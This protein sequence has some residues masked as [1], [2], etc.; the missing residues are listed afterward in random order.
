MQ[1]EVISTTEQ[2]LALG[3]E[4]QALE[5]RD[6][7][8]SLYVAHRFVSAWWLAY[9]DDPAY[10]LHT[11]I[12]RHNGELVAVAPLVIASRVIRGQPIR[13]LRW[14]S[15]GDYLGPVMAPQHA[16]RA[17]LTLIGAIQPGDHWDR[18]VLPYMRTDSP[19]AHSVLRSEHN[20]SLTPFVECPYI[21]VDRYADFDDFCARA[22]PSHTRKYRNKFLRERD[23]RFRVYAGNESNILERI[24]KVHQAERD[25]LKDSLS[26]SER[27]SLFDDSRRVAHLSAIYQRQGDTVTFAYEDPAGEVLAYRTC[28]VDG[29][30]LLSWNSAYAPS[31]QSYRLGKVLQYD[32]MAWVFNRGD[33]DMFDFGAG[34]Y[35]WKFEWTD[36]FHGTYRYR[37]LGSSP[38]KPSKTPS[39]RSTSSTQDAPPPIPQTAAVAS[40]PVAE[41][42]SN[43]SETDH[44]AHRL[45]QFA[46]RAPRRGRRHTRRVA[47]VTK[48]AV[49]AHRQPPVIWYIPHPDDETIFMGGS[50]AAR[51]DRRHLLV[52]LA[53]GGASKALRKVNARLRTPLTRE[54]FMA[55]RVR[56]FRAAA[57]V[58]GVR[59]RD[60]T[61][62]RLEDGAV[63]TADVLSLIT[64]MASAY[65]DAEHRT[66]SYLDPH[67]DHAAAGEALRKAHREGVVTDCAFHLPVPNVS[68]RAGKK[69][70]LSAAA[71]SRKRAALDAYQVWDPRQGRY[72]IG[73]LSVSSLITAQRSK[74]SEYT[75]GPDV[76]TLGPQR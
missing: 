7:H 18:T 28:F 53:D 44:L 72:G 41:K 4:W 6:P 63:Q 69:V 71:K 48:H 25:Y 54:A 22:L 26:R 8:A 39:R 64:A 43:G 65:P 15:H 67:R 27:H 9:C 13:V 23:A 60:I 38:E 49:S 40:T 20:P 10:Q 1:I 34:R 33:I 19:F 47:S 2:L 42:A 30:T 24:G 36:T 46:R 37:Q 32:V 29:A 17:S 51:P 76:T 50:I 75:H 70:E 45:A 56:E 12:V 59:R 58:L 52:L 73:W 55:A 11:L 3:D 5:A 62:G 35:P 16:G 61:H 68:S 21:D 74:P 66:M 31:V 57:S 14:A